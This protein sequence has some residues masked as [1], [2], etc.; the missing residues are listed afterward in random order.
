MLLLEK[1]LSSP[2]YDKARVSRRDTF[3]KT[4]V[5]ENQGKESLQ[6]VVKNDKDGAADVDPLMI[7]M[8]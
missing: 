1:F 6:Q 3:C 7:R 5:R 4:A 8:L 2:V